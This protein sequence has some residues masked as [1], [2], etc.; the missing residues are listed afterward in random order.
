MTTP[1]KYP[2]TPHW[3]GSG[4]TTIGKDEGF[5]KDYHDFLNRYIVITEK[6]DGSNTLLVDGQIFGRSVYAE[7]NGKWHAMTKKHHAWKTTDK[8]YYLFYGED[9][10]GVHSIEYNPVLENEAFLGFAIRDGD[11]FLGW[12]T[13]VLLFTEMGI[14]V[15]PELWIGFPQTFHELN[16][17]V[18]NLMHQPS[19]LGGGS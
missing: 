4:Y 1:I 8:P 12:D 11:Y 14:P 6:V 7:S 13:T 10:Y 2:R 18:R 3:G 17:V 19:S 15:V 16:D 5:I 9:I